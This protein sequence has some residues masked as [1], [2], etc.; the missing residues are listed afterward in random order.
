MPKIDD[1][2]ILL[3]R[4][5]LDSQ[6][7]SASDATLRVMVYLLLTANHKAKFF[8][9]VEIKRGQTCKSLSRIADDCGLSVKAV[10]YAIDLLEKNGVLIKDAPFG[11]QQG[12][13]ITICNYAIYQNPEN[14][15]GTRGAHE[16]THAVPHEGA[17]NNK[18]KKENNEKNTLSVDGFSEEV[19]VSL[20]A[21]LEY[22]EYK[23]KPVGWKSQCTLVSNAIASH[24][25]GAVIARIHQAIASSWKG[26]NLDRLETTATSR[27]VDDGGLPPEQIHPLMRKAQ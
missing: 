13:R 5:L 23:Y 17:S 2:Y 15:K 22:K 16:G 25:E 3:S 12:Q 26:M 10:R 27:V 9:M 14:Y 20:K 1:G 11:A 7:W 18:E 4:T 6:I 8:K 21:W 19:S 24:G